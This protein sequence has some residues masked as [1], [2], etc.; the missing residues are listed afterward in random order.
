M[1]AF[2]NSLLAWLRLPL[3]CPDDTLFSKTRGSRLNVAI[4][5]RLPDHGPV[6]VVVDSTQLMGFGEGDGRVAPARRG[7]AVT[8]RKLHLGI[9]GRTPMMP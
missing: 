3:T 4:Q 8:W 5:R 6:N 1:E 2:V 7:Q 9:A